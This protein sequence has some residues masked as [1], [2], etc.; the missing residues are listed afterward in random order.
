MITSKTEQALYIKDLILNKK[1]IKKAMN[2]DNH[3]NIWIESAHGLPDHFH[4]EMEPN[5]IEILMGLSGFSCQEDAPSDEINIL[6]DY[7]NKKIDIKVHENMEFL[8]LRKESIKSNIKY[9]KDKFKTDWGLSYKKALKE[10]DDIVED[11]G[12]SP[13][14]KNLDVDD[15]LDKINKKGINSLTEEEKRFLKLKGG[16]GKS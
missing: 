16:D 12:E 9:L 6:R 8:R 2:E 3:E 11:S 13:V 4:S 10:I 7:I 14:V 15:I 1:D 5:Y